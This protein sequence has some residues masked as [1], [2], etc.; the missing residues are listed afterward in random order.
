ML[1]PRLQVAWTGQ[2]GGF[3]STEPA[4]DALMR[5]ESFTTL[6]RLC[7]FKRGGKQM[8]SDATLIFRRGS[9]FAWIPFDAI[10]TLAFAVTKSRM[11]QLVLSRHFGRD[12]PIRSLPFLKTFE[13]N[14][15]GTV[16]ILASGRFDMMNT[17]ERRLF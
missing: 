9:S 4:E 1:H 2:I 17:L 15:I 13:H 11:I 7:V 10:K 5:I 14:V 6:W 3:T 12:L 16:A 8:T